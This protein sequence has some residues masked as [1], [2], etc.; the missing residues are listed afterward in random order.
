MTHCDN[1]ITLISNS[2]DR[3]GYQNCWILIQSSWRGWPVILYS[4]SLCKTN[5][6]DKEIQGKLSLSI[7]N[8]ALTFRKELQN[9]TCQILHQSWLCSQSQEERADKIRD[10]HGVCG[11]LGNSQEQRF[12]LPLFRLV[13][14]ASLSKSTMTFPSKQAKSYKN[15]H[16]I[17]QPWLLCDLPLMQRSGR[18]SWQDQ[19]M[20]WSL[21]RI[22]KPTT[23]KSCTSGHSRLL[24]ELVFDVLN[25]K[26]L[27]QRKCVKTEM[28]IASGHDFVT[29]LL[30]QRRVWGRKSW[31]DDQRLAWN[32]VEDQQNSQEQ[33]NA[34][35]R[36]SALLSARSSPWRLT[37]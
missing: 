10:W 32:F 22:R 33:R 28:T 1:V 8:W 20:T 30:S 23:I 26:P 14:K 11:G 37:F 3:Q 21:W 19:R 15:Q 6:E 31:Q 7:W 4:G 35:F 16:V 25:P 34:H 17:C 9:P 5:E 36:H 13:G 29:L 12:A 18:K 24:G 2:M 27:E